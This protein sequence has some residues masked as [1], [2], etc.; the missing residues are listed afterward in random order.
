MEERLKLSKDRS[1]EPVDATMYRSLVG[2]LR[3]LVHSR[4]NIAFA[5]GFVSRFMEKPT[6]EHLVAVKQLLRY[7]AGTRSF[8][9][10]LTSSGELELVG[11]S[12]ADWAGDPD[13]RRSTTGSLFMIGGSPVTWQSQKQKAVALSTCEAQ[14]IE[15]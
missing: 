3:Y 6:T 10:V 8:G 4:P 5:V 2:G 15:T 14:Y 9:C 11:Y 7:I 13:D 12:D 1:G